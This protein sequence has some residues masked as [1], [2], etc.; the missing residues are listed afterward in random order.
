[1]GFAVGDAVNIKEIAR[2][3][4]R[5]SDFFGR[6]VC[7]D[8]DETEGCVVQFFCRD[9]LRRFAET[10]RD[11]G[12]TGRRQ[13]P[14]A[15]GVGHGREP[16]GVIRRGC[17][18]EILGFA[19]RHSGKPLDQPLGAT[20]PI[21]RRQTRVPTVASGAPRNL[22][23][24]IHRGLFEGA[25]HRPDLRHHARE[26]V[27]AQ[28]GPVRH[29]GQQKRCVSRGELGGGHDRF[30]RR[31]EEMYPEMGTQ[32][33]FTFVHV[34]TPAVSPKMRTKSRKANSDSHFV[35]AAVATGTAPG[36]V[37]VTAVD[38][39]QVKVEYRLAFTGGGIAGSVGLGVLL[40][41]GGALLLL[42]RRRR[43]H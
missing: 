18:R 13:R 36:P 26:V 4:S 29:D 11:R 3:S 25:A 42:L 38:D 23:G 22:A 39:A 37:P 19:I 43:T 35:N 40:L 32:I 24:G 41:G 15:D 10:L 31:I 17:T 1:M 12:R 14:I 30:Y 34:S 8:F 6:G 28:R 5:L 7:S 2:V 21:A 16:P 9:A 27:V 33:A 20:Q